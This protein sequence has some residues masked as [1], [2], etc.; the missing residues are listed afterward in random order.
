MPLKEIICVRNNNHTEHINTKCPVLNVKTD[1]VCIYSYTYRPKIPIHAT[2]S[3]STL[4]LW[5][6]YD[7]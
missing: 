1:G 3:N 2:M 4:C 6:S 7:S 5:V